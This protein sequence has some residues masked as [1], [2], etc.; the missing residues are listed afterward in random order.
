M[1]RQ[2]RA[3]V[4]TRQHR[5][6]LA[7]DQR[8]LLRDLHRVI[9]YGIQC[10]GDPVGRVEP[11]TGQRTHVDDIVV[12]A[13][14][15][16]TGD[17]RGPST[18]LVRH[19][20]QIAQHAGQRAECGGGIRHRAVADV[21]R[22]R[23]AIGLHHGVAHRRCFA[24]PASLAGIDDVGGQRRGER[25]GLE[26]TRR[27]VGQHHVGVSVAAADQIIQVAEEAARHG[28]HGLLRRR[29]GPLDDDAKGA[30]A[31]D[32][33]RGHVLDQQADVAGECRVAQRRDE[34]FQLGERKPRAVS[35]DQVLRAVHAVV[36]DKWIGQAN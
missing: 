33:L 13:L 18:Q 9:R 15:D 19:R 16:R 10:R 17:R 35:H 26:D 14:I 32:G 5:H 12:H 21:V 4:P 2:L 31:I 28:G 27:G 23:L 34:W 3:G 25:I 11:G 6:S 24:D 30:E 29:P 36:P 20:C 1:L 22:D 8:A 7:A